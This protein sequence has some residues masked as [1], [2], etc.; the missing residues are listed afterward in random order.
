MKSYLS[1]AILAMFATT[2]MVGMSDAASARGFHRHVTAQGAGG[3]GYSKD[4]ERN[5]A[6]GACSGHRSVQTNQGYGWTTDHSRACANG[7]CNGSTTVHANNGNSWTRDRGVTTNGDGTAR[8][9][10]NTSGPNGS[11]SRN[12]TVNRPQD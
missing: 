6:A 4:V 5:C 8:W 3:R 2:S 11:V 12:G 10:S 7:S 9:Y 1:I